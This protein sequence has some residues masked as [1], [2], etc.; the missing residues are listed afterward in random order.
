MGHGKN[1]IT[2]RILSIISAISI[3]CLCV[4]VSDAPAKADGGGFQFLYTLS[5]YEY[6]QEI[7]KTDPLY[8]PNNIRQEF[9]NFVRFVDWNSSIDYS[10]S[11]EDFAT[12]LNSD[13]TFQSLDFEQ[14]NVICFNSKSYTQ[15]EVLVYTS[16]RPLYVTNS[17][18]YSYELNNSNS[19]SFKK[20]TLTY[21]HNNMSM[22]NISYL[23][24]GTTQNN[25]SRFR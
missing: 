7:D 20:Y 9:C 15:T 23:S 16:P 22:T 11:I 2:I 1:K 4:Y 10:S 21:S 6:L 17:Y 24:S 3:L 25:F 14:Y 8:N 5:Q 18:I 13:T 19:F 12:F